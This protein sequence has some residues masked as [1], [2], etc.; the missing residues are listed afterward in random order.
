MTTFD[1]ITKKVPIK[2]K[3]TAKKNRPFE[4]VFIKDNIEVKEQGNIVEQAR[5]AAVTKERLILQVEKLV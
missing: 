4:I 5:N 1:T 3:V 2:I